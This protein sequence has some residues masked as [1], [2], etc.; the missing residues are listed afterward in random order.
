MLIVGKAYGCRFKE[1]SVAK[2]DQQHRARKE[3]IIK[4]VLELGKQV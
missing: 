2:F 3:L 1:P 4:S